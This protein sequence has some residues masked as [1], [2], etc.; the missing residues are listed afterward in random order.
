METLYLH[1]NDSAASC[2][3]MKGL[4][5]PA[6]AILKELHFRWKSTSSCVRLYPSSIEASHIEAVDCEN[7]PSDT[8]TQTSDDMIVFWFLWILA[9]H[10]SCVEQV[11]K[12]TICWQC[13]AASRDLPN[14]GSGPV[15]YSSRSGMPISNLNT[16]NQHRSSSPVNMQNNAMATISQGT[17]AS[18]HPPKPAKCYTV[19]PNQRFTEVANLAVVDNEARPQISDPFAAYDAMPPPAPKLVSKGIVATDIT[20]Q[21]THAA[22]RTCPP[23]S[24][25]STM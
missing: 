24:S 8:D 11:R 23:L 1:L 6:Y 25:T 10:G 19:C 9:Q 13:I 7:C 2:W 18:L 17:S 3:G 5:G 12:K 21:F 15:L 22:R 16:A 14:S 4:L 20:Q